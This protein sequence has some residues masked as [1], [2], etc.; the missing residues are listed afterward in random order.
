MKK[1]KLLL[2]RQTTHCEN[3]PCTI[4]RTILFTHITTKMI[5]HDT[6]KQTENSHMTIGN[7]QPW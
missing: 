3:I 1:T 4:Y 5:F 6:N 2:N 7:A